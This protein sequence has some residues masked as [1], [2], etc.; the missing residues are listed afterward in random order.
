[1]SYVDIARKRARIIEEAR[2]IIDKAEKDGRGL[3]AKE[4]ARFDGL[5]NEAKLLSAELATCES[6]KQQMADLN[7]R[8]GIDLTTGEAVPLL[9]R[10]QRLAEY[11]DYRLPDGTFGGELSLGRF[12]RGV[13]TGNW[14]DAEAEKRALSEGLDTAGGYMVPAP[15]AVNVID[16]ARN[17]AVCFQAGAITVPMESGSLSVAVV[18]SDPVA[19]WRAENV[20]I[21]P[22]DMTFGRRV[23]SAKTV[24]VLIKTSVE[25]LEDAPNLDSLIQGAM[26]Q[27]VA[28]E[29]DRVI[30]RGSGTAEEPC[31]VRN[32]N[33]IQVIDLG[34]NG[35]AVDYDDFSLAWQ[36]VQEENGPAEGLSVVYSPRE[37]GALDRLKDG[38]G[39]PRKP[40]ASWETMRKFA[41]NQIPTD[42]TK[43]TAENASEAYVGPFSEVW[44]GLRTQMLLEVSRQAADSSSSA[45]SALQVWLRAYLRADVVVTRPSHF[46]LIDGIV[47]PS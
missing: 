44:V 42:L 39:E 34:E 29:L 46:V 19:Y 40:P 36:L 17:K 22:S 7:L 47:P 16:A 33:G 32:T 26:S 45:F 37:A 28:L 11:V 25:L 24:A 20:D 10:E 41:T 8:A 38:E 2:E 1:M 3:S 15:L 13:A 23:L 35:G 27:A 43:G 14:K 18:E 5:L 31:G 4:Q 12:V 21:T 30:L 9:R 6:P